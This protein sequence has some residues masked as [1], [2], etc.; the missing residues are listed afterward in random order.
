M[1]LPVLPALPALPTFWPVVVALAI[2]GLL[3]ARRGWVRELALLGGVLFTWLAVVALG[4][5]LLSW[6][7]K[8]VL[9][10]R[11]TWMGGFDA[12]D[13]AP[14]LRALRL[15]PPIDPW[16][17]QLFYAFLFAFGVL[18]AYLAS[19][20]VGS[21]AESVSDVALGALAGALNGYVISYVLLEQLQPSV[22]AGGPLDGFAVLAQHLP[23]VVI[24]AVVGVVAI[25]LLA[26]LRGGALDAPA[27]RPRPSR[28]NG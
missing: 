21:R 13:P 9:M 6:A 8:I 16:H 14:L 2:A 11:F 17:P 4:F 25:A 19:T 22:A 20:R 12:A 1:S 7:N 28:T 24:A 23:I 27:E 26:S 10:L 18:S 3:G 15:A 5:S